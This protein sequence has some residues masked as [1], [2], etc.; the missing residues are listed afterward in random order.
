MNLSPGT[1]LWLLANDLKLNWRRFGDLIGSLSVARLLLL[2]LGGG[3][4]LHLAAWP[5]AV[6][7]SPRMYQPESASAPLVV[8]VICVF[9]WMVAQSLF[10]ATR[11]LFDRADLDLL[12][13]SPIPAR[14]VF[15]AKA[16]GIAASTF[17]SIA[18]LTLPVANAGALA[19]RAQW[20]GIYPALIGMALIAAAAGLSVSIG[21]FFLVGPRRA[22]VYTQ[23]TG[24]IIGG[25]FMLGAQIVAMLP[26]RVQ[27]VM[28][29]WLAPTTMA[30]GMVPRSLFSLPVDALRGDVPSMVAV[31]GLG[32]TLF[33]VAVLCL[34]ERFARA[35][36]AAS[37]APADGRK[38]GQEYVHGQLNGRFDGL[39]NARVDRQ[40]NTGLGR[41]LRRKEWRL[42]VRDPSLFTQLGLQIVYTVP[43]AVVLLRSETLPTALALAPTIVVIAAQIASSIAWIT[44]SGE[45]APELLACAPVAPATVDRGKLSAVA[46]PVMIILALPL[47]CLASISLLAAL[48]TALV[49]A[50]AGASTALV[51][52]WHPMPGSRRG[53]LRRH[54]QSKLIALV[55]H[56]FAI[57]WAITIVFAMMGSWLTLAPVLVVAGV[58]ALCHARH[59]RSGTGQPASAAPI[60][61]AGAL[62]TTLHEHQ[63]RPVQL[64]PVSRPASGATRR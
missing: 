19:D 33:V 62:Q 37:G 32:V 53:M 59:R 2:G 25:G 10:A 22:R 57:L 43:V 38:P 40:F 27:S 34:G 42:L 8:L 1:F 17:G 4:L 31:V 35:T 28:S 55:E 15:A 45:D 13:G 54:S 26:P 50:C 51:N 39:P 12:L 16:T 24:A 47:A 60:R 11:T 48:M 21:L 9:S 7:L 52:F 44:V 14:R 61:P 5:V 63:S 20:L 36:L 29:E 41:N 18:L 30:N 46:L 58:L 3:A 56:G 6:W 49:A 23:L 64:P